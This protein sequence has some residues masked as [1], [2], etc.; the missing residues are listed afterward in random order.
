MKEFKVGQVWRDGRGQ[1]VVIAS[2]DG[3]NDRYPIQDS[4]GFTYTEDGA[5]TKLRPT[6]CDLVE[7]VRDADGSE[8]GSQGVADSETKATR[9]ELELFDSLV[10]AA[11]AR[12]GASQA[13]KEAGAIKAIIQARRVL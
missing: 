5:F 4:D 6:D 10:K 1:E 2:L 8:S 13:S 11:V 12:D 7:L 9:D 3:G